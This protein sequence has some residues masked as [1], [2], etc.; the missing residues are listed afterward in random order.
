[1]LEIFKFCL[2]III[3]VSVL[4]TLNSFLFGTR[5]LIVIEPKNKY[6]QYLKDYDNCERQKEADCA[7]TFCYQNFI[8]AEWEQKNESKS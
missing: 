7:Y 5:T 4:H 3:I 6:A 1:M 2:H 8:C